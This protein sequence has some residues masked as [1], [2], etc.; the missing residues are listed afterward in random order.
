MV[1]LRVHSKSSDFRR[2]AVRRDVLKV[3]VPY[4]VRRTGQSHFFNVIIRIIPTTTRA[5][6]YVLVLIVGVAAG[7]L[8]GIIG[9]GSSMMLMPVLVIPARSWGI[10]ARLA[11]GFLGLELQQAARRER[12]V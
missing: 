4:V 11:T 3:H 5:M 8:S 1:G 7:M 9:T 12:S 10:S 2:C 6:E